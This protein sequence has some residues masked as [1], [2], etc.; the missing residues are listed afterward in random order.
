[1]MRE[2]VVPLLVIAVVAGAGWFYREPLQAHFNKARA[3]L[4]TTPVASNQPA[5]DP[6]AGK[7]QTSAG[8]RTDT[9]YR[10]VDEQGVT[11]FD[12]QAGSGREA[13]EID[14]RRIQSLS[15]YSAAAASLPEAKP[16]TGDGR[17]KSEAKRRGMS[18]SERL[19][20]AQAAPL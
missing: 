20:Q 5:D 1:M 14:Q 11:H 3:S 17:E 7:G 18:P 12:Q 6:Q 10:W 8:A 2:T 9:V 19:P 15:S 16:A 13:V 4:V